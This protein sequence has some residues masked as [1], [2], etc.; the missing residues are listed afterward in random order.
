MFNLGY[1]NEAMKRSSS[2]MLVELKRKHLGRL[3]LPSEIEIRTVISF[4]MTKKRKEQLTLYNASR[5]IH[6]PFKS[7]VLEIFRED[8]NITPRRAWELF[9]QRHPPHDDISTKHLTG[10]H[11]YC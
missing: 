4:L 5:G 3:D 8:P 9:Q 2:K 10:Y 6:E 11:I 7:T 1:E